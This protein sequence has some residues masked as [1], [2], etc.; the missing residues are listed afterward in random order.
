MT[1][2][3]SVA[4]VPL[5]LRQQSKGA[6]NQPIK[7]RIHQS[8]RCSGKVRSGV[9]GGDLIADAS[10]DALM[11]EPS[12]HRLMNL[13]YCLSN[14]SALTSSL[15]PNI[16]LPVS[17]PRSALLHGIDTLTA[18]G[19]DVLRRA[20]GASPYSVLDCLTSRFGWNGCRCSWSMT[21]DL[22][23][24]VPKRRPFHPRS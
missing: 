14:R 7:H 24:S 11:F 18:F 9:K 20:S 3:Q 15:G 23:R 8:T 5:V 16:L 4:T 19:H 13:L 10:L 6:C 22:S 21:R 17:L 1:L 12:P 2:H